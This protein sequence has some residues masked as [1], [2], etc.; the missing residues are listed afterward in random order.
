VTVNRQLWSAL[1]VA[2]TPKPEPHTIT[3]LTFIPNFST[4]I[5][6]ADSEALPVA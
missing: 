1:A 5:S 3:E 6:A 4:A 2:L